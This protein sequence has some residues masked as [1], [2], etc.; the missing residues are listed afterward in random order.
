MPASQAQELYGARFKT[1]VEEIPRED[2]QYALNCLPPVAWTYARA[3]QSFKISERTAGSVTAIYVE[4]QNRYFRF[5]DDIRTP[6][7]DC[8]N[9]VARFIRGNPEP[10]IKP[11]ASA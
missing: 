5:H 3:A 10:A 4:M 7:E 6:H 11:G 9:R 8:C 2:F 1:P